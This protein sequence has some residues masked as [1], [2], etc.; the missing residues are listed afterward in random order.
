[1]RE[2]VLLVLSEN[3]IASNWV[4]TEIN[5]ALE[6]E[7]RRKIPILFPICLDWSVMNTDLVWVDYINKTRNIFD[8][9][10]WQDSD[11]YRQSMEWLLGDLKIQNR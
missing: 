5:A 8:F 9:S 6:E 4:E 1:M 2:K 7:N 11:A 10:K 3:S